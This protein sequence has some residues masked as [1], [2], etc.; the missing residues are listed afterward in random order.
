M[1]QETKH[2]KTA[3]TPKVAD[4]QK[5][6]MDIA[7]Q[8]MLVRAQTL[9][10][11]T[12]FDRAENM[13]PCNIGAQG[14]CCKICGMGPCRLPLSKIDPEKGDHR[15]GL[16]GATP[17]TIAARNFA[18]MVAG[19]VAAHSD[20]GR[21]VAEIFLSAALKETKNY[22]IKDIVKLKAVAK[23]LNVETTIR[24]DGESRDRD[25]AEIAV[26]VGQTALSEW[27]K[28]NGEL[29]YLKRAPASLY[30]K[31]KKNGV[32]PRNIDR[33]IVDIMHRTHMG[34]DQDYVNI[35]Q[36]CTRAALA[37]GWGG[38]MLATD[39]QDVLFGTP[40]PVET[41]ANLGILKEDHVN[42]IVHGHEPALSEMIVA[43]SAVRPTRSSN[44]TAYRQPV[45]F[46]NRNWSSS[47][48]PVMPWLWMCNAF[49]KTLPMWPS[50]FTPN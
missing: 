38:S 16:C 8:E 40:F 43:V 18:R 14:T 1:T 50:V 15:K 4:A 29:L 26:D 7:T 9:G 10:I 25:I 24:V 39:L 19:G 34:V 17:N 47:P 46:C 42:I 5:V 28:V 35:T 12:I 36:Q 45:V 32:L 33:E 44:D 23:H 6:T 49:F 3:K 11:E 21:N 48:V 37:D 30:E 22:L 41:H 31:W 13:K 20:H 2:N 27:G